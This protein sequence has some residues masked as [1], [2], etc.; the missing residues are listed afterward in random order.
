MTRSGVIAEAWW[1]DVASHACILDYT[2]G[3]RTVSVAAELDPPVDTDNA[4]SPL[5]FRL[6]PANGSLAASP[7][8]VRLLTIVGG[9]SCIFVL[10]VRSWTA[11]SLVVDATPLSMTQRPLRRYPRTPYRLGPCTAV[12]HSAVRQWRGLAEFWVHDVSSQ[13]VGFAVVAGHADRVAVGDYLRAPLTLPDGQRSWID[14]EVIW[15][16]S[17][18]RGGLLTRRA[19]EWHAASD[20][21]T[22]LAIT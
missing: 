8:E 3:E 6:F 10:R 19:P 11:E 1:R 14:G 17:D 15:L 5:R 9:S 2:D 4:A 16:T 22:S 13:G 7:S 21:P 20:A 12:V 18:G